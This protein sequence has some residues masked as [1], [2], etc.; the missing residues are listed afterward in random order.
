MST[1]RSGL[2]VQ[3]AHCIYSK[4]VNAFKPVNRGSTGRQLNRSGGV[5]VLGKAY[6]LLQ[7]SGRLIAIT[8]STFNLFW[9]V[10]RSRNFVGPVVFYEQSCIST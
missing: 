2:S 7:L 8:A 10:A 6:A 1:L 9:T 4:R 3:S 5:H